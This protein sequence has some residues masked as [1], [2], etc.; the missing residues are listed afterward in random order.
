MRKILLLS[1]GLLLFAVLGSCGKANTAGLASDAADR[2]YVRP[3]DKDE[4]YMFAS[5][6]FS[7]QIGVNGIP[8]G[9]LL[10]VIPVF[11]QYPETGYGYDD[12]TKNMLR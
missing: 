12:T 5:G 8:S 2:V 9:R 7:G 3:G 1:A 10:R 4:V 6:G 11:S